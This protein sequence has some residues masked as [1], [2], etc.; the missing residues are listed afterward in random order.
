MVNTYIYPP[1][2]SMRI[3]GTSSLIAPRI[4]RN[5]TPSP[6]RA[7]T[8]KRRVPTRRLSWPT[9]SPMKEY[10]QTAITAGL[11]IDD[12]AHASASSGVLA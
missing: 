5:S 12:F 7:I 8:C 1:A 4:C 11:E 10:I 2:P 3:I 6:F 9:P